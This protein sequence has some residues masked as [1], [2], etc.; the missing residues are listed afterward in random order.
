MMDFEKLIADFTL[1]KIGEIEYVTVNGVTKDFV[2]VDIGYKSEAFIPIYEFV[3]IPKPLDKIPVI[4]KSLEGKRGTPIVE[5]AEALRRIVLKELTQAFENKKPVR[6]VV[7]EKAHNGYKCYIKNVEVLLPFSHADKGLK[8]G[9]EVDVLVK[10]IRRDLIIVSMKDYLNMIKEERKKKT[11]ETLK[12]GDIVEG[13]VTAIKDF[14][15]FVDV[16]GID[17]LMHISEASLSRVENLNDLFNVGSTVTVKVLKFDRE[18][19]KL[20]LSRKQALPDP[21]LDIDSKFKEG[22]VVEGK[23]INITDFGAF[24]YLSEGIEGLLHISEVDWYKPDL[25]QFKV[26]DKIRV[27]IIEINKKDKRIALSIKRL[28]DNPYEKLKSEL[29]KGSKVKAVVKDIVENIGLI[30]EVNGVRGIIR[31]DDISWDVNSVNLKDFKIG[32]EVECVVR[33]IN[34]EEGKLNLSIKHLSVDPLLK[35]KKGKIFP[36]KVIRIIADGAYVRLNDEIEAFLPL[37]NMLPPPPEDPLKPMPK[38]PKSAFEVLKLDDQIEVMVSKQDLKNREIEV[39]MKFK[40]DTKT[41]VKKPDLGSTL[42]EES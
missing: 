33:N 17:G 26:G 32:D 24:V 27:K 40:Q 31:M 22:D 6:V 20:S 2:I 28:K 21:W 18:K 8:I 29:P 35:Y 5:H 30:V 38:F 19:L 12:E 11:L 13:V 7:K 3:E 41:E 25:S 16:G 14:G 42:R 9:S 34:V 15:V 1:P 23:I 39:T 36:A 4:I 10:T 37:E